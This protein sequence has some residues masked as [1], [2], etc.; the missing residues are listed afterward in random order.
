MREEE[1]GLEPGDSPV[2]SSV[3]LAKF[4]LKSL[5]LNS[6]CISD[7]AWMFKFGTDWMKVGESAGEGGVPGTEASSLGNRG[8]DSWR[9]NDRIYHLGKT[10][11]KV[12]ADLEVVP[13]IN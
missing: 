11:S 13:L 5:N 4:L 12:Q 10:S 8:Q 1:W 7:E 6:G 9:R 2:I 3:T